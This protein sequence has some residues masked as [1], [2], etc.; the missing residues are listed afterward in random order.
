[1]I[2]KIAILVLIGIALVGIFALTKTK[3]SPQT[4]STNPKTPQSSPNLTADYTASFAIYTKGTFRVFTSPKYHGLSQDV[5]IQKDNPNV[6][7][8]KKPQI[9]W[10][11]F[12][13]TLPMELTKDCLT[14][15]T[16]ETFC[17]GNNG[18]LKFYINGQKMDNFLQ[19]TINPE[20]KALISF[21]NENDDQ[22]KLQLEKIQ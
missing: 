2:I 16:K 4:A 1:M 6:V 19:E 8:V 11:D 13:K 15:G 5:F 9:T 22:I 10:G 21:G 17:T 14:T 7:H 18:A 3:S 12:F 20:D